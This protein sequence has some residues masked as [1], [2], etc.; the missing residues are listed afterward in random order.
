MPIIRFV[1]NVNLAVPGLAVRQFSGRILSED[2]LLINYWDLYE[3]IFFW[4]TRGV[5][6]LNAI[7]FVTSV[8]QAYFAEQEVAVSMSLADAAAHIGSISM[9]QFPG[10]EPTAL[11]YNALLICY[12]VANVDLSL[13]FAAD[14]ALHSVNV[15][16]MLY[17]FCAKPE[18]DPKEIE[19]QRE[20]SRING[21]EV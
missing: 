20:S 1:T 7:A 18:Q 4:L 16:S 15:G 2:N 6:C 14:L 12:N 21:M 5:D 11:I 17:K 13:S 8:T 19:E 10:G 3:R 9:L